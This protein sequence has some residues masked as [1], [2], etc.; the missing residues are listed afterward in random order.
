MGWTFMEKAP[1]QGIQEFRVGEPR[2]LLFAFRDGS[3]VWSKISRRTLRSKAWCL[4]GEG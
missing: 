4:W 1:G 2:H 3:G